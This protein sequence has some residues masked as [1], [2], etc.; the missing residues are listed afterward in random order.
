MEFDTE[1]P[2]QGG[3][4]HTGDTPPWA[5]ELMRMVDQGFSDMGTQL[6]GFGQRLY[7][8]GI[9]EIP[10]KQR[11]RRQLMLVKHKATI[12][13]WGQCARQANYC[14]ENF[15]RIGSDVINDRKLRTNIPASRFPVSPNFLNF[16]I[17]ISIP[18]D[19]SIQADTLANLGS[20]F[21]EATLK[22]IPII[23]LTTPTIE[24]K[25]LVQMNEE[26]YS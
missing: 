8:A 1:E 5:R 2:P 12:S 22:N 11:R 21:N 7:L 9:P 10:P 25:G 19:Q 6:D 16:V 4:Q 24:A 18:R 14:F 20:A 3:Y 26:I 15:R 17:V 23:H 13:H